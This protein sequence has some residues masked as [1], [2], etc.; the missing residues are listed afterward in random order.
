MYWDEN[1]GPS[2]AQESALGTIPSESFNLN[3]DPGP[4][5]PPPPPP[6]PTCFDQESKPGF[7][8]LHDFT[9]QEAAQFGPT[10]GVEID[11]AGNLFGAVSQGAGYGQGLIY[12]FAQKNGSWLLNPLYTFTGGADGSDP[13]RVLIGPGGVL[14]S[15]AYYAGQSDC[16]PGGNQ[17]CGQIFSLKPSANACLTALCP[18]TENLLYQFNGNNDAWSGT[19]TAIDGSGN[20]YGASMYGGF[21][22]CA[23]GGCGAIFKVARS[24]QGWTEGLLYKFSGGTDGAYPSRV[25]LGHDG[26][27]YG[28]AYGGGSYGYGVVFQLAQSGNGLEGERPL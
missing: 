25:I 15:E 22:D 5:P 3:G 19:V 20:L 7:Q 13:G 27:L 26:N 8:V 6:P 11:R 23:W 24:G 16:G 18:W 10:T 2:A 17:M 14:Y 4:P 28:T 1:N 12:E 21:T 9:Q